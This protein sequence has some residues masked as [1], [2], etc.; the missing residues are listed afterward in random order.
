[1]QS[2]GFPAI[3]AIARAARRSRRNAQ[4]VAKGAAPSTLFSNAPSA[5]PL[6]CPIATCAPTTH[7]QFHASPRRLRSDNPPDPSKPSKTPCLEDN[8]NLGEPASEFESNDVTDVNETA[9][10]RLRSSA[11]STLRRRSTIKRR[12]ISDLP[13]FD[14]PPDFIA[15]NVSYFGPDT[16]P[17]LPK[18][19]QMDAAHAKVSNLYSK[20]TP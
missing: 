13:P 4:H 14:L 9:G 10:G 12:A 16:Q 6:L 1:M 17:R 15:E 7:R 20:A 3:S 8:A 19:L 11:G 2:S 5:L 18:P